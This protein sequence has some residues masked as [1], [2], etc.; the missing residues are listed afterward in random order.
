[1]INSNREKQIKSEVA[2]IEQSTLSAKEYIRRYG[3]SF[4]LAQF[5]RY[6]TKLSKEGVIGVRDKRFDGNQRKLGQNEMADRSG[7][8]KN[9]S[10]VSPQKAQQAIANEFGTQV[11][12]STMSKILKKLGVMSTQ[13]TI[14]TERVSGA[15]FELM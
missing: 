7:F 15:G 13:R 1:M 8:I 2:R 3:A 6:R 5:Y 9:Q 12:R 11:H 4:S 10:N 14:K